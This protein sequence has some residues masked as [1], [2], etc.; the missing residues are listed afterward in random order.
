MGEALRYLPPP[1]PVFYGV[2]GYEGTGADSLLIAG[3]TG[4]VRGLRLRLFHL[5]T[6]CPYREKEKDKVAKSRIMVADVKMKFFRIR[7]SG[8]TTSDILT[9]ANAHMAARTAT[10]RNQRSSNS[11]QVVLG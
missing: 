2:R 8:D 6:D 11:V 1:P 9:V 5:R 7:G 10:K 3:K 4:I